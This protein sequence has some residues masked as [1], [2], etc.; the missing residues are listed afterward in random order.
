MGGNRVSYSCVF[1][2]L[3]T[4]VLF[5]WDDLFYKN[6]RCTILATGR[7]FFLVSN[8]GQNTSNSDSPPNADEPR[9]LLVVSPAPISLSPMSRGIAISSPLRKENTETTSTKQRRID[10]SHYDKNLNQPPNFSVRA[11][12]EK[13]C[14]AEEMEGGDCAPLLLLLLSALLLLSKSKR[15]TNGSSRTVGICNYNKPYVLA[16]IIVTQ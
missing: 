6:R 12:L 15:P 1:R 4:A 2:P 8:F 13:E 10:K 11:R 3:S 16:T 14:S 5:G 9:L 7:S